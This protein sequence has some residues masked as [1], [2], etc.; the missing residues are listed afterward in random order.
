MGVCHGNTQDEIGR[1]T[2]TTPVA[3]SDHTASM[4]SDPLRRCL[5]KAQGFIFPRRRGRG[6]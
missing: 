5:S 2:L 6:S 3:G 4:T 1:V